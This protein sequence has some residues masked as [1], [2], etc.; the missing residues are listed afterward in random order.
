MQTMGIRVGECDRCAEWQ[1]PLNGEGGLQDVGRAK[2]GIDLLNGLC[3][4]ESR[5][6]RKRSLFNIYIYAPT[7]LRVQQVIEGRKL[8]L[9]EAGEFIKQQDFERAEY[10]KKVYGKK[11]DDPAHYHL[12][13]NAQAL[14]PEIAVDLIIR[15]F[16]GGI[17][18]NEN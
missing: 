8:S 6:G 18:D 2:S 14:K 16:K 13:I 5:E 12:M 1:L 7:E 15:G 4:M 11:W 3:R 9:E 10:I 17:K